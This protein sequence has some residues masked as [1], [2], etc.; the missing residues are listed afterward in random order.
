VHPDWAGALSRVRI[1]MVGI[2]HAG[3]IGA[4]ARVMK[5]M[6][7]QNLTLVSS[8]D[9][10]PETE[11]FAR[12][13]GAYDIVDRAQYPGSLADALADTVM[14]VGTSG[15][16]GGKRV[17]AQTPEELIPDLMQHALDG[18]VACVFGRESRGLTNEELK[19]CTHHVII[20]TDAEF[21]SMNVAHAAAVIAY[22]IFKIACRPVNFQAKRTA[23]ASLKT[24]EDMYEHIQ[25]VLVRAG[26]LDAANPLRMMRD[27]RRILNSAAMDDRDVKIVRGIFRRIDNMMRLADER[28]AEA[29]EAQT[30]E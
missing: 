15:R 16:L 25:G 10:G 11:A 21:A 13:S 8:T 4:V 6:S 1:V 27:V 3:N 26:F 30:H 28:I 17:T 5:N 20:P 29:A 18:P 12:S 14:A 22:E 24:R 7:L 2:T 19:L 23:P 9:A